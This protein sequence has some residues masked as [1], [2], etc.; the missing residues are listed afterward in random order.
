MSIYVYD[1]TGVLVSWCPN[2]TDPVA[3][4]D[5]LA[6][7]CLTVVS[8]LPPL[9]STHAWDAA[10]K[11]VVVVAAPVQPLWISSYQFILLFTPAETTAIRTSTDANV[12]HWLFALSVAQQVDLH[13]TSTVQPGLG[14]LASLGLIT[15]ARMA[16]II[17]NQP[18]G[19]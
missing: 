7:S 14:Y 11:T 5:V 18:P 16:Q 15:S 10:S 12:Q 3:P 9:D 4:N 19:A 13:D 1:S 2:D 17:A 6:A 8:G